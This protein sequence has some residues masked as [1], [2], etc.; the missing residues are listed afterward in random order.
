MRYL[1]IAITV[2]PTFLGALSAQ[3]IINPNFGYIMPMGEW[4]ENRYDPGLA[5][6]FST[7]VV[8]GGYLALV[9]VEVGYCDLG[10]DNGLIGFLRPYESYLRTLGYDINDI[11]SN[12]WFFSAGVKVNILPQKLVTPYVQVGYCLF[13]RGV[14]MGG[15]PLP[16]IPG[17]SGQSEITFDQGFTIGGGVTL[18]PSNLI[19][20]TAGLRFFYGKGA[21]TNEI[22]TDIL[23]MPEMNAEFFLIHAG[24]DFL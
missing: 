6:L 7:E 15:M 19:S 12:I 17:Y 21:G 18:L 1:V 5:I 24:V 22:D 16:L 11:S 4:A 13:R 3:A 9:P 2:I 10:Q 14:T 8:F 20:A 23:G